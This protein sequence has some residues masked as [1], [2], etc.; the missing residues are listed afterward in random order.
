MKG[1]RWARR[2]RRAWFLGV[3]VRGVVGFGKGGGRRSGVGVVVVW[4]LWL[5]LLL[6]R[7]MEEFGR[8]CGTFLVSSILGGG[9]VG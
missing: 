9:S 1:W 2:L 8:L 4:I 5:G 7:W 6:M 3:E